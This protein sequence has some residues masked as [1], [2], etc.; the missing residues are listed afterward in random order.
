M[1]KLE[2]N[3]PP[4]QWKWHNIILWRLNVKEILH[5]LIADSENNIK[6]PN[7]IYLA[8]VSFFFIKREN[9]ECNGGNRCVKSTKIINL[10][11]KLKK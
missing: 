9:Y 7:D 11:S 1:K 5:L 6:L 3:I 4:E 2:K 10:V 8:L